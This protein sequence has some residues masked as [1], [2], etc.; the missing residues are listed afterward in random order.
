MGANEYAPTPQ[1]ICLFYAAGRIR[2]GVR[3]LD[4]RKEFDRW[5]EQ[6][7][8]EAKAE[9]LEEMANVLESGIPSTSHENGQIIAG[10][11]IIRIIRA[12]ADQYRERK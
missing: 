2:A 12:R 9:A 11:H 6:V 8:R 4:A 5:L 7:K 1:D 3:A 10:R